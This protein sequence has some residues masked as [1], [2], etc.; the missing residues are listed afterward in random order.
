MC[1]YLDRVINIRYVYLHGYLNKHINNAILNRLVS[2]YFFNW[3]SLKIK[4]IKIN[5]YEISLLTGTKVQMK[6]F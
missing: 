1:I 6:Y 4:I 5:L 2:D 3:F